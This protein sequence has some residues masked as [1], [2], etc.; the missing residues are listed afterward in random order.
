MSW[1]LT[2]PVGK[3]QEE[4][5]MSTIVSFPSIMIPRFSRPVGER[6]HFW[7]LLLANFGNSARKSL[8]WRGVCANSNVEPAHNTTKILCPNLQW[9]YQSHRFADNKELNI[10]CGKMIF[11]CSK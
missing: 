5:M 3:T 10:S 1:C 2:G 8:R 4:G 7:R 11:V 6:N 9:G